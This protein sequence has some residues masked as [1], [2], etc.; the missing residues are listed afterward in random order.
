MYVNFTIGIAFW[1]AYGLAIGSWPIIL[2]NAATFLLAATIRV[3]KV[4]HG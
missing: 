1:F 2:A 3:L 4:H